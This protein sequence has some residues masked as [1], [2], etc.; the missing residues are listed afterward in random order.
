M[1]ELGS[2]KVPIWCPICKQM[3]KGKSTQS[4]YRWGCCITCQIEFIEDREDRWRTG[5]R[6]SEEQ[7]QAYLDRLKSSE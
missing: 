2:Y 4:Y 6:P 7:V 5:W 3:M 1:S